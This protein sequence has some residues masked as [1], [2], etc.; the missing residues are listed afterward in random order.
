MNRLAMTRP[1]DSSPGWIWSDN[2]NPADND[3]WT[4]LNA[5]PNEAYDGA[6]LGDEANHDEYQA[7]VTPAMS[8]QFSLAYRFKCRA[9]QSWTVC[10]LDGNQN[11]YQ[12]AQAGSLTV[13]GVQQDECALG[14]NHPPERSLRRSDGWLSVYVRP[15]FEAMV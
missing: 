3:Q 5:S 12:L 1:S 15:G 2:T 10:D 13:R 7:N 6:G 9:G 14:L 4:W 8:G 11:G